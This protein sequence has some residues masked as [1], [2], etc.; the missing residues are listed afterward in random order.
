MQA[1]IQCDLP[2][3]RAI[4]KNAHGQSPVTVDGNLIVVNDVQ[5]Q[6]QIEVLSLKFEQPQNARYSISATVQQIPSN[7]TQSSSIRP[8]SNWCNY[9]MCQCHSQ[10]PTSVTI[11]VNLMI[12][13]DWMRIS[14]LESYEVNGWAWG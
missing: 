8:P 11:N 4:T 6:L 14:H 10:L 12:A 7:Q 13:K 3:I 5:L 9:Q 2:Q 1:L